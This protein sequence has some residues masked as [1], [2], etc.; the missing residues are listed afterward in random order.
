MGTSHRQFRRLAI[1]GSKLPHAPL[2]PRMNA[3]PYLFFS[4]PLTYS[5]ATLQ[6]NA[7]FWDQF[8]SADRHSERCH[9]IAWQVS[10]AWVFC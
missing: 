6:R 9:D 7:A 5:C 10:A 1:N 2:F 4:C 8:E 3:S